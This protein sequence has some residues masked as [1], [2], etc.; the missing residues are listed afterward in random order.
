MLYAGSQPWHLDS[1]EALPASDS[2]RIGKTPVFI[3]TGSLLLRYPWTLPFPG[4]AHDPGQPFIYFFTFF[5]TYFDLSLPRPQPIWH[6]VFLYVSL[7]LGY[8]SQDFE[9]CLRIPWGAPILT[10]LG[11]SEQVIWS[12]LQSGPPMGSEHFFPHRRIFSLH[13][14]SCVMH[15]V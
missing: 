13:K 14:A 8:S 4:L 3:S 15:L 12:E 10:I 1:V 11:A 7:Q 9:V 6:A 5:F 2:T